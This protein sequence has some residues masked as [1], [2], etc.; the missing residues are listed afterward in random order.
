MK[1]KVMLLIIAIIILC[2][3]FSLLAGEGRFTYFENFI[4]YL[5]LEISLK[6]K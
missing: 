1:I 2:N 6:E 4:T 5:I 3:V